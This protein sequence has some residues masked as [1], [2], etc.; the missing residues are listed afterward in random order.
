MSRDQ[1]SWRVI[2][3]DCNWIL[4]KGDG[5]A[6]TRALIR[7]TADSHRM[8]GMLLYSWLSGIEDRSYD[9]RMAMFKLLDA[10][11]KYVTESLV[12]QFI[13]MSRTITRI[14]AK[15]ANLETI[16]CSECTSKFIRDYSPK[17]C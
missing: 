3:T 10:H 2:P 16:L 1:D 7:A 14:K 11:R 13:T 12:D 6:I 8:E 9:K 15:N 5:E 4:P 17:S